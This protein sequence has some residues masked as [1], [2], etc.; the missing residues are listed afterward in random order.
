MKKW[1]ELGDVKIKDVKFSI[2]FGKAKEEAIKIIENIH[3]PQC[4]KSLDKITNSFD[5]NLQC[6]SETYSIVILRI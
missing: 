6:V 2:T 4:E 3:G 5:K 1:P